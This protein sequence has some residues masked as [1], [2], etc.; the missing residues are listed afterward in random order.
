VVNNYTASLQMFIHFLRSC[1]MGKL[2]GIHL[3][4]NLTSQSAFLTHC[5]SSPT[6]CNRT[7]LVYMRT[8]VS[9]VLSATNRTSHFILGMDPRRRIAS[10]PSSTVSYNR[11]D[12]V[13]PGIYPTSPAPDPATNQ[14]A[15][16]H[17]DAMDRFSVRDC[18]DNQRIYMAD[19]SIRG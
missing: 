5:R 2:F 19:N 1:A 3:R 10:R 16:N 14:A 11:T 18:F 15:F 7:R 6:V 8:S 12:I 17:Q 13:T 9:A 4:P